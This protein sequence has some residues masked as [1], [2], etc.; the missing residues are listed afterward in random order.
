MTYRGKDVV[1]KKSSR[2]AGPYRYVG[3]DRTNSEGQFAVDFDGRVGTHFKVFLKKTDRNR[4]TAFYI[5]K[6]VRD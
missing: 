6:I 2:K 4:A 1:L 3:K 5:G